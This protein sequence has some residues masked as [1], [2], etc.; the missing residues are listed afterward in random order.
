MTLKL[1]D[2]GLAMDVKEP[3]YTVCGTPT[4]VAPEILSEI[5]KYFDCQK[6][7]DKLESLGPN[8][9]GQHMASP[10]TPTLGRVISRP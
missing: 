5:G 9:L 1:A 3:I 8:D 7:E 4:Y 6:V 2:F 10:A